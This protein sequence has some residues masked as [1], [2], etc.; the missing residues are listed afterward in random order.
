MPLNHINPNGSFTC[1]SPENDCES[2]RFDSCLVNEYC[3][4]HCSSSAAL[5]LTQFLQCYEG[6]YANTEALTDPTRREP[7]MKSANLDY[8]KVMKCALDPTQYT[9]IEIAINAS[10]APMYAALG[11]NPGY[12]PHIFVD[13]AHQFNDSWTSMLRTLC[14]K[15]DVPANKRTPEAC[16]VHDGGVTFEFVVEDIDV[17][18]SSVKKYQEQ[19]ED[20][21][22][23]GVNF[24]SSEPAF[25]IHWKT[26]AGDPGAPP[27]YVNVQAS[28]GASL[29]F[30]KRMAGTA[31]TT[32]Q[33]RLNNF[34]SF[35]YDDLLRGVDDQRKGNV[36]KYL[37]WSLTATKLFGNVE[38]I[39]GARVVVPPL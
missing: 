3:Y 11:A 16:A 27:S 1:S 6:P 5:S 31:A 29:I 19:V 20:A 37:E 32:V 14:N 10:R 23:L 21:I 7:C 18:P 34:L 2:S 4:P 39:H 15:F 13:S 33:V 30:A 8:H 28:A 26:N 35:Y 22:N 9:P 25:P 17:T 12:F 36:T 38:N 24:A